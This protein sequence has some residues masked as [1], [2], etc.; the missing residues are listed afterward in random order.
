[1]K[2]TGARICIVGAGAA[3]L[4]AAYYLQQRGYPNVTVLDAAD[5]I[6]GKCHS[7]S[8]KGRSFDLGANYVTAAYSE[9]LKLAAA[10]GA[11]L[12]TETTTITAT[13][14]RGG[15]PVFTKPL[16]AITRGYSLFG[17]GWA[18]LRYFWQRW[19]LRR[20]IDTPGFGEASKDRALHVSFLDWLKTN[21]LGALASMFE[22]P[23]TIMGYGYLD[24]IPAAY[25]L[26]YM[27]L[28]TCWNLVMVGLGLPTRWPK[29]FVDGFERFWQRIAWRLDVRLSCAIASIDRSGPVR[30]QLTDGSVLEFDY[31]ILA[32]PLTADTLRTFLSLSPEENDLFSRVI[33][34]PYVITTYGIAGLQLPERIVGM[35]PIPDIGRP[36]AITQQ[37]A[38]NDFVQFYTRMERGKP[39][40]EADV[41]AQIEEDV[42]ALGATLP[43]HYLTYNAWSYF[44]H[45]TV[46]DFAQGYY[47]RFEALQ[48]QRNT[49]Y[50]GGLAAFELVEPIVEYSRHLIETRF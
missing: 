24:E 6:G 19:R 11:P 37:F 5:R 32:C 14:P 26:K 17:F 42:T 36:W 40:T 20:V 41:I 12:Y 50:C 23:L 4:S 16:A 27:S 45:V 46:A 25:A 38:D 49:F 2:P 31:L 35:L 21:N 48:G 44:P 13:I 33:S 29:R 34:N 7:V 18:V 15:K 9:V 39:F 22:V 30:V 47:E 10:V 43:A 8:Y 3:G 28:A 1:M